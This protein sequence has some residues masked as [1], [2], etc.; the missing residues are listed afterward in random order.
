ME[1]STITLQGVDY[2]VRTVDVRS[3][4]TFEDECYAEV[5]VAGDELWDAIE[6]AIKA[7]DYD[8]AKLDDL[9][10]YY[11]NDELLR[12]DATDEEI[13]DY[14][15]ENLCG[16]AK[17]APVSVPEALDFYTIETDGAGEKR[18]RFLGFTY[19]GDNWKTIDIGR[20][21]S[22]PLS[23]FVD[24]MRE[25]ED[26]VNSLYQ[27]FREFERD[28]TDRECVATINTFFDGK[29]ADYRLQFGNVT[30]ETPNGKYVNS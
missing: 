1:K 29:P 19:N 4:P 18:I 22:I 7:G 20:A 10:F 3:I 14:M 23:V 9:I 28:V 16:M 26:F 12:R 21:E 24:G 13:V 8:A 25:D 2:V 17:F 5:D 27:E 11:V 15:R 30:M 6:R